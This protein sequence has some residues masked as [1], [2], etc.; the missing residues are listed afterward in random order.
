[1]TTQDNK[2]LS[3]ATDLQQTLLEID[4]VNPSTGEFK[5]IVALDPNMN[6]G[7]GIIRSDNTALLSNLYPHGVGCLVTVDLSTGKIQQGKNYSNF[8]FNSL[9]F[10]K[11][12][13]QTFVVVSK[14]M[15]SS[16]LYELLPDQSLRAMIEIPG[17]GQQLASAYSSSKHIFFMV[18]ADDNN[19]ISVSTVGSQQGTIL[20]NVPLPFQVRSMA[21]DDTFGVLYIWGFSGPTTLMSMDYTTGKP[22]KNFYE[23]Y[24]LLAAAMCIDKSGTV[25]YSSVLSSERG[26]QLLVLTLNLSSGQLDQAL[27]SRFATAMNCQ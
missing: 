8:V 18:N 24:E 27:T 2:I 19:L 15:S 25:A 7:P 9:G 12:T 13:S 5:Q 23:S 20:Y 21:F 10:D 16:Q 6:V 4:S 11:N 26:Q 1:M 22:I 14:Q 17:S 3:L